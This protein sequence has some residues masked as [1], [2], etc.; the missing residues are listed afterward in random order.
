MQAE[1]LRIWEEE[2]KTVVFVTHSV[3]EAIFL[4]DRIVMISA[5]PGQIKDIVDINLPRPRNRTS[6]EANLIRDRVLCDLRSEILAC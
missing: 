1:L 3:D 4:G 6:M 5:R 2:R